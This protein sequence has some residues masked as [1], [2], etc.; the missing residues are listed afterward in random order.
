MNHPPAVIFVLWGKWFE[1]ATA[2]VF[3]TEF[4]KAGLPVKL[5]SLTQKAVAGTH[6]IGLTPDWTLDQA[7][8]LAPQILGIVIPC[9]ARGIQAVRDDPRFTTLLQSA[10]AQNI[11]LIVGQVDLLALYPANSQLPAPS[12]YFYP[13]PEQLVTFVRDMASTLLS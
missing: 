2:S 10:Y 1:E 3:I 4:R 8:T 5:V 9:D 12:L 11:P 6:G 13:E 7:L